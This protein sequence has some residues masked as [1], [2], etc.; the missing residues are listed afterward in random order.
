MVNACESAGTREADAQP[1]LAH[2]RGLAEFMADGGDALAW[3]DR[4]W[5]GYDALGQR[6]A[7]AV[8][9]H[10]ALVICLLDV[11]AMSGLDEWHARVDASSLIETGASPGRLWLRLGVLARVALGKADSAG[12]AQ[13]AVEL[14]NTLL[15]LQ[16]QLSPHERLL[17]ALVLIDYYFAVTRFEQFEYLSNLVE[18]PVLFDAA[19]SLLRARWM[20]MIGFAHYQIGDHERAEKTWQRALA[21]SRESDHGGLGLKITLALVRLLLDRSR[22]HEAD[23]ILDTLDPRWGAGRTSMLIELQQMRARSHLL[24]GQPARALATLEEANRLAATLALSE[25]E[26]AARQTDLVQIYIA[27][28][29]CDDAL[30]LLLRLAAEHT[31]MNAQRTGCLLHL[32]RA[33]MTRFA[34]PQASRQDLVQALALAQAARYTMYFRLLPA[35]AASVSALALQADVAPQFVDEVIRS[36]Q[37]PAPAD[38][39]ARWPWTLWLNLLGG[40]EMRRDGKREPGSAK[41]QQKPLELLRLLACERSL[42]LSTE[43][44]V[45]AL[46]PDADDA[47]ARKS[48]EMAA[49]RLRR[50]L[51]DATLLRVGDGRV[52]L[53]AART[54]SDVQQRRRL[55]ERIEALAMRTSGHEAGQ[56][57]HDEC[58]ALLERVLAFTRGE[59]L[60]GLP[61]SPWLEAERQRCR[62]DTVRAALAGATVLERLKVGPAERELLEAALRIEPL[63]E[64]LVRRLM[65]AHGRAGQRGD[66]LR[67]FEHYRQQL[68]LHGATP[69][70]HIEAQWRELLAMPALVA[71]KPASR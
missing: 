24:R 54:S 8:T 40:F 46:W 60:P 11:G 2:W 65:N 4:A 30:A 17:A 22:V 6:E 49:L 61:A 19:S 3:L 67:V 64:A 56:G 51:G 26:S 45:A 66:A 16:T 39:D 1:D 58:L 34:D 5:I 29:R 32:L 63:A 13:V 25:A 23:R 9:A 31:E 57:A 70:K 53:D 52:G 10:A 44:A 59:L 69:S 37:L 18:H 47:A 35:L 12:A 50:L 27:L 38:A 7:A 15:P 48:F 21:L 28:D 62:N 68:S 43:A 14:Q 41:T 36:R 20:L 55:I 42:T 71:K 33:W